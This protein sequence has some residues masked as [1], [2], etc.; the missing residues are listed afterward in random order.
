MTGLESA[1]VVCR[2]HAAGVMT[3]V[4]TGRLWVVR[5][6]PPPVPVGGWLIVDLARHAETWDEL[7]DDEARE[8][9]MVIRAAT[10]AIRSV[11]RCERVYLLSF[12]EVA[13]HVHVHLVPR[14]E[15]DRRTDGWSV[16]DHYRAVAS[17]ERSPIHA[18]EVARIAQSIAALLR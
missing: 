18:G 15:S 4:R 1:C 14:H 13:R 5:H 6:H 16:A 11:T 10:A 12:A 2:E 9:G 8:A 17:G 3:P 7:T